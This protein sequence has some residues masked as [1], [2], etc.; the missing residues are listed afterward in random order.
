VMIMPTPIRFEISCSSKL[1]PG[2]ASAVEAVLV[3]VVFRF[4][5]ISE[6]S[7]TKVKAPRHWDITGSAPLKVSNGGAWT[8]SSHVKSWCPGKNLPRGAE[9]PCPLSP[10]ARPGTEG[11]DKELDPKG[12]DK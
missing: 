9:A 7:P 10:I 8:G 1:K 2:R 3:E 5:A 4:T 6:D 11:R 12:G